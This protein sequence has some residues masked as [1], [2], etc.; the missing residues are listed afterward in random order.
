MAGWLS[1]AMLGAVSFPAPPAEA[2]GPEPH[3]GMRET[4]EV[5][6]TCQPPT[7]TSHCYILKLRFVALSHCNLG[8]VSSTSNA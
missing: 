8:F 3:D 5:Q 7:H 1:P 6:A 2:G 4:L